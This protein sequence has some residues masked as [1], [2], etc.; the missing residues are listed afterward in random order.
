M[1]ILDKT[2]SSDSHV[3][4]LANKDYLVGRKEGDIVIPGDPSISRRHATLRVKHVESHLAYPHLLP[5]LK[6]SEWSKYGTYV[7]GAK[8]AETTT[9]ELKHGD[10]VQFGTLQSRYSVRYSRFVVTTSCVDTEDKHSLKAH[11]LR[12]GGHLVADWRKDSTHLVMNKI[13]VTIKVVCALVSQRAIVTPAYILDLTTAI[14]TRA[15]HPQPHRYIPALA[16]TSISTADVSFLPNQCRSSI[17]QGK[18]F[19]FLS[20]RQFKKLSL[21]VS[22]GG[23]QPVLMEED[24]D[25]NDDSVLIAPPTCVMHC[26]PS[27]TSQRL[28][29]NARSWVVHVMKQLNKHGKRA[30]LDSELGMAVLFCST[31]HYCNPDEPVQDS[32]VVAHMPSQTFTEGYA[33]DTE[34]PQMKRL[35][36]DQHP[37]DVAVV[38]DSFAMK[39]HSM[40]SQSGDTSRCDDES[41][42][43]FRC[44][45][46]ATSRP[47][48]PADL[49]LPISGEVCI[50]PELDSEGSAWDQ[51]P[52]PKKR[53]LAKVTD[54]SRESEDLFKGSIVAATANSQPDRVDVKI[55]PSSHPGTPVT[56]CEAVDTGATSHV[57]SGE[58]AMGQKRE[59]PEPVAKHD[60]RP[61]TP[62]DDGDRHVTPQD[63]T[64]L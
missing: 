41:L 28:T 32:M 29:Q 46:P 40:K 13:T 4:L 21:A 43:T 17:F 51:R 42:S 9:V 39:N 26:N 3:E 27:D 2:P 18:T 57:N 45:L 10:V 8:L 35:R 52:N 30:I 12:L 50:K 25:D 64:D 59:Q 1:W 23:G 44:P 48:A 47:S 37:D 61:V 34:P 22:L 53:K 6:L 11:I 14:E 33:P 58:P 62:Q 15:S 55:E 20:S 7:N 60:G 19:I 36:V 63:L 31:A 49:P 5:E 16:E 38:R 54:T 56:S 24:T